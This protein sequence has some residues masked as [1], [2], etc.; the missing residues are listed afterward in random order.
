MIFYYDFEGR[1]MNAEVS[2]TKNSDTISV[3]LTDKRLTKDLPADLIFDKRGNRIT[4]IIENPDNK[5]LAE[6][7]KVIGKRLQEFANQG[8]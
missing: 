6:L 8:M 1:R 7:Q 3:L 5:R 2:W 4:Y